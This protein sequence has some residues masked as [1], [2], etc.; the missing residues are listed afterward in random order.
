MLTVYN[1]YQ[2]TLNLA[3]IYS[4]NI[5]DPNL[6]PQLPANFLLSLKKLNRQIKIIPQDYLSILEEL[7]TGEENFIILLQN[8]D[9]LRASGGFMGSYA[10][11]EI[12]DGV[13]K[14]FY[15]QDIYE[16]DGQ[17]A[18]R[19]EAPPGVREYLSGEQGMRLPDANWE[20]DFPQ[21][22]KQILVYFALGKEKQI[23]HVVAINATFF[24][25]VLQNLGQIYVPDYQ[26]NID[27]NNFSAVARAD[28]QEFFPGSKQKTNFLTAAFTQ[29]K[30]RLS[31]LTFR[32][33]VNLFK[34][35][36][37]NLAAKN[38]LFYS[39]QENLQNIFL[40][41][42]WAGALNIDRDWYLYLLESNVGV[43]KANAQV[44][45]EVKINLDEEQIEITWHN[46]NSDQEYINYQRVILPTTVKVTKITQDRQE[47]TLKDEEIITN[48]LGQDFKQIG[49]LA[50]VAP[51]Q[52]ST[53]TI[54]L[55]NHST[56]QP[57]NLYLI[58]QSGL[59][60]TPY[61]I[62]YNQ[63]QVDWFIS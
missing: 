6:D 11:V 24:N 59:A 18:G 9:E 62:R 54:Q 49:F 61:T 41:N 32:E 19:V 22:A 21:A 60:A 8:S 34:V 56:N 17:F 40:K 33:K 39:S 12:V 10:R 43:N 57:I 46:Q 15:I 20:A 31:Q 37:V 5:L 16:A 1:L 42:N 50:P 7:L 30:I 52:K 29:I 13:V 27:F 53:V 2:D 14:N 45:R 44:S 51:Q 26:V 47:V 55:I 36:K 23:D 3:E 25:Q 63:M 58:K 38:I 28:R 48:S 35:V 4:Q